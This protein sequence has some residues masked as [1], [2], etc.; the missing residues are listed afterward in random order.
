MVSCHSPTLTCFYAA[1][2]AAIVSPWTVN[3]LLG[4]EA[5]TLSGH[6]R[7]TFER[8]AAV[9][10]GIDLTRVS[11]EYDE[12]VETR[13]DCLLEKGSGGAPETCRVLLDHDLGHPV[14]MC[15]FRGELVVICVSCHVLVVL[16]GI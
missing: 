6:S 11:V 1:S 15:L 3:A 8:G 12:E 7:V 9:E 14:H 5:E 10:C 16:A 4:E 13:N 2:E